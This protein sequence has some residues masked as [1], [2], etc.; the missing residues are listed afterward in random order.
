MQPPDYN[1]DGGKKDLN[2]A[3]TGNLNTEAGP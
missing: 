1:E 3:I 2:R